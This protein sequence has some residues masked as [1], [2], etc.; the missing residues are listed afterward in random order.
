MGI[1]IHR[2]YGNLLFSFWA[3]R[4]CRMYMFTFILVG[5]SSVYLLPIYLHT[6]IP[7]YFYSLYIYIPTYNRTNPW[8]RYFN[9]NDL[10]SISHVKP[11]ITIT[12][13][14]CRFCLHK[15]KA[16]CNIPTNRLGTP[17]YVIEITNIQRLNKW[18]NIN[19]IKSRIGV[20]RVLY[21][22]F[23]SLTAAQTSKKDSHNYWLIIVICY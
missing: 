10:V 18:D 9:S 22:D 6:Y 3:E 2:I 4:T 7:I 13:E 11:R 21:T 16:L 20:R 8:Q 5:L 15:Y 17:A 23:A 1:C 14:I 19:I 12:A